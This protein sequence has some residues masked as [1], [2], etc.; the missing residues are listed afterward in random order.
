[1]QASAKFAAT[2]SSV[3][4][5]PQYVKAEPGHPIPKEAGLVIQQF[6]FTLC[7]IK[8]KDGAESTYTRIGT[9]PENCTASSAHH[10]TGK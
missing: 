6:Y 10:Q 2:V 4:T 9:I 8:H 1:M 3:C 7:G 5:Y